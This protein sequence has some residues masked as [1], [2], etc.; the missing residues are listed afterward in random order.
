ME[1]VKTLVVMLP[2][3][4]KEQTVERLI[5]L[6]TTPEETVVFPWLTNPNML[7]VT[8]NLKRKFIAGDRDAQKCSEAIAKLGLPFQ[9]LG[10]S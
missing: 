8:R 7:L 9:Y 2:S 4:L 10:D 5:E 1:E 3:E 6:L